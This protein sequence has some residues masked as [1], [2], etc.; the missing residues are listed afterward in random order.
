MDNKE[1]IKVIDSRCG[2]G[3]TTSMIQHINQMSEDS[4]IIYITP[5]LKE[6]ER[7]KEKCPSKNFYTPDS[8]KGKGS[9]MND[10]INLISKGRNVVSTHALFSNINDKLIDAIRSHE[11]T[12]VL[13][14]V[15]NVIE[16]FDLYQNDFKKTDDEKE[17]L[18]KEDIKILIEK[19]IISIDKESCAV[20]W[21]NPDLVLSKYIE[22]KNLAE[23]EMLYY[24]GTD[25]LIWSF[26]IEVFREGVFSKIFILT[27]QFEYQIQAYYYK[28]FGLEYSTYIAK[29]TAK[30]KYEFLPMEENQDDD[31]EW[32]KRIANKIHICDNPK[33]NRIG[34][35]YR[36]VCNREIK[37]TLSKHW[38]ETIDD[39]VLKVLI[40]NIVNFFQHQTNSKSNQRMW[41]SFKVH[42]NKI[43]NNNLST[44]SWIE[45][46]ARA[47]NDYMDKKFI[48]YP[49]NRYLNPFFVTFFKKKDIVLD[50][51]KFAL[52]ELIQWVFR[53]A[54]RTGED[55]WIYIPSQRMRELF[56]EWLTQ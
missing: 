29:Q 14:E 52:S 49:I 19:E 16:K 10:M 4:K 31:A 45:L 55:I 33:L 15:M 46:N 24:I 51:D 8:K 6:C 1:R 13:D 50:Q 43:K 30:D 35:Y 9:K 26:P 7:I 23:R 28:Y 54:I 36:D 40:Q 38:F 2:S 39:E 53:S 18:I 47:T 12:L 11:Y 27:Y 25:L 21:T 37:T 42:K 34:N 17:R 48:A 44:K 32:R 41:T 5:F 56:T 22:L 3:K 20:H